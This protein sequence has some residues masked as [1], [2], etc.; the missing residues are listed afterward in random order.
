MK[1]MKRLMKSDREVESICYKYVEEYLTENYDGIVRNTS[2]Q[3]IAVVMCVLSRQ[4]GFGKIR[5]H[6]LKNDL[7]AEF[8]KMKT[9]VLGRDYTVNDCVKY[10]KENYD[11]DFSES[12]YTA[13]GWEKL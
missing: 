9:G 4:Y 6:R 10:L 13:E 12:N 5:L 1:S 3:V 2:Y 11:I 7:E 8:V